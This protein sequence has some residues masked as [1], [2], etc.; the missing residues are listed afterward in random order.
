MAGKKIA[1]SLSGGGAR[2]FFHLGVLKGMG[3]LGIKV[4]RL[5]GTSAG[6]LAGAFF[7]SGIDPEDIAQIFFKFDFLK[8]FRFSFNRKG[9]ISSKPMLKALST[10]VF[11]CIYIDS[12]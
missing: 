11:C 8:L 6:A 12:C 5:L 10:C 9:L 4:D 3:E 1:L 2:G 7:A